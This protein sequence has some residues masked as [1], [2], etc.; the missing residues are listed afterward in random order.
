MKEVD[1][2]IHIFYVCANSMKN[3][4]IKREGR[5]VSKCIYIYDCTNFTIKYLYL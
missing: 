1:I 4:R 3:K 2:C 5:Y